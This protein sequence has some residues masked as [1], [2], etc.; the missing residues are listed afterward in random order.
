MSLGWAGGRAGFA[1]YRGP[2]HGKA[3]ATDGKNS[4][5]FMG[6]RKWWCRD[7]CSEGWR[8]QVISVAAQSEAGMVG[9]GLGALGSGS[10]GLLGP[11]GGAGG[12]RV[13][14]GGDGRLGALGPGAGGLR[15]GGMEGTGGWGP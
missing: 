10:G 13:G 12:L 4:T 9:G 7:L 2:S 15:A 11:G 8:Y 1:Q 5:L 6:K 14:G 3:A